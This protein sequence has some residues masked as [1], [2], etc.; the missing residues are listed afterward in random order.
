MQK[1]AILIGYGGMG[2]RYF[3]SLT[4]LNFKILAVCDKNNKFLNLLKK[5]KKIKL[6]TNYKKLLNFKADLLC[7]AS[8][9]QSR[10]EV[11]K[12]FCKKKKLIELLLKNQL[13][14]QYKR[15]M[16]FIILQKKIKLRS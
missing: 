11:I 1:T 15:V 5:N 7:L 8:N 13:Q 12:N 16:K 9:T 3:K 4:D 14:H 10:F 2:Q 6:T